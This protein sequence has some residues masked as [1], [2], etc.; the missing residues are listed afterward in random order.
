MKQYA[1]AAKNYLSWVN[2]QQ[3]GVPYWEFNKPTYSANGTV[4]D[5]NIVREFCTCGTLA[6]CER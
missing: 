5:A 3:G 1:G 6:T 4:I 2:D